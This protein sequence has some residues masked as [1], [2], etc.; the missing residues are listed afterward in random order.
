M[1]SRLFIVT[2]LNA[3]ANV[4]VKYS[5]HDAAK[6]LNYRSCLANNQVGNIFVCTLFVLACL[7]DRK[8]EANCSK[9]PVRSMGHSTCVR[10]SC[11]MD[12]EC[13]T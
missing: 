9:M 5:Y 8:T 11:Y 7:Y 4:K 1:K 3:N 10:E 2:C 6:C 12:G 13:I